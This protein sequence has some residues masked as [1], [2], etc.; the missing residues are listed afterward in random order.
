MVV[1]FFGAKI[2]AQSLHRSVFL[3]L[4]FTHE[5][6][7]QWFTHGVGF[8][9]GLQPFFSLCN[10]FVLILKKRTK[11]GFFFSLLSKGTFD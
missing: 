4:V 3:L 10:G 7:T 9:V 11:K 6:Y 1:S 2:Y 5:I 8:F